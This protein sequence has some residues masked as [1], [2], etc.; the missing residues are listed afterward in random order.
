M[1]RGLLLTHIL[2]IQNTCTHIIW[3][4]F[5]ILVSQIT[6]HKLEYISNEILYV[7]ERWLS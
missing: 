6:E 4:E 5:E 1:N 3:G 2:Q 7:K